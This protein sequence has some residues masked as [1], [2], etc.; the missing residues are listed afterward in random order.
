M[1]RVRPTAFFELI[2]IGLYQGYQLYRLDCSGVKK[3]ER[4]LARAIRLAQAAVPAYA[5]RLAL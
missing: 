1:E 5:L 3:D 4:M 2:S